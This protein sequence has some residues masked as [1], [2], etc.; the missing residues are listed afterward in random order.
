MYD[1]SNVYSIYGSLL[2]LGASTGS[3]ASLPGLGSFHPLSSGSLSTSAT[4]GTSP[5][6]MLIGSSMTSPGASPYQSG[7][8]ASRYHPYLPSTNQYKGMDSSLS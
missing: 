2:G 8:Y 3:S 5:S 4:Y 6:G 1:R 7:L